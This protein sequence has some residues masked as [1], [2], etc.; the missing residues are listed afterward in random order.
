MKK[1]KKLQIKDDIIKQKYN[2]IKKMYDKQKNK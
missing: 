1:K 2:K